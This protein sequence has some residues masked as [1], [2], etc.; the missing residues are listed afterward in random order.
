V[1]K[2]FRAIGFIWG[3]IFNRRASSQEVPRKSA[4]RSA[5]LPGKQ[6]SEEE[7]AQSRADYQERTARHYQQAAR[8]ATPPPSSQPR[9]QSSV[10]RYGRRRRGAGASSGLANQPVARVP[11]DEFDTQPSLRKR[12]E[13]PVDNRNADQHQQ[14]YEEVRRGF[15]WR[16][17]LVVCAVLMIVVFVFLMF[18]SFSGGTAS[19]DP[20]PVPGNSALPATAV[21][22]DSWR[23]RVTVFGPEMSAEELAGCIGYPRGNGSL[24]DVTYKENINDGG[25]L[26]AQVV[27]GT[28]VHKVFAMQANAACLTTTQGLQVIKVEGF[29]PDAISVILTAEGAP[30]K[31]EDVSVPL[32]QVNKGAIF[33]VHFEV[34]I[35]PFDP[36]NKYLRAQYYMADAQGRQ[37]SDTVSINLV[38]TP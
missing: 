23:S 17:A 10:R 3:L 2:F 26:R 9:G 15:P 4:L 31:I 29:G 30:D 11:A 36:A 21:P 1:K 32:Q 14:D 13:T 8:E 6:L 18:R 27:G 38:V 34:Q 12:R 5:P 24:V 22:A 25:R 7:W 16:L 37:I 19:A 35:P 33:H 28:T 20:T